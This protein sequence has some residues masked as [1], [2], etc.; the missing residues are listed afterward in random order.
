MVRQ[1][2]QSAQQRLAEGQLTQAQWKAER[3]N[4][5]SAISAEKERARVYQ[6]TLKE[7]RQS[8]QE[9]LKAETAKEQSLVRQIA[10]LRQQ[11]GAQAQL[12]SAQLRGDVGSAQGSIKALKEQIQLNEAAARSEVQR[13]KA[14]D[15]STRAL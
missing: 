6:K 7:Q 8:L 5:Q 1:R 13:I 2:L 11:A 10:A 9:S 15:D 12:R 4:I 14:L 3:A